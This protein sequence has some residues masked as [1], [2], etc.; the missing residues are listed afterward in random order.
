MKEIEEERE[1]RGRKDERRNEGNAVYTKIANKS[2]Q[3]ESEV[4]SHAH[5]SRA[6]DKTQITYQ[7][8]NS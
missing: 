2:Q 8:C 5:N 1:E 4:P 7:H 6:R 3:A